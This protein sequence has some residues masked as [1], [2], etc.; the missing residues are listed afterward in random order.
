MKKEWTCFILIFLLCLSLPA[1][2]GK[3][4]PSDRDDSI[5]STESA[6]GY[7]L[8]H[9]KLPGEMVLAVSQYAAGKSI[10]L[11]GMDAS[12]KPLL[13]NY[14]FDNG[15]LLSYPIPSDISYLHA[16]CPSA[17]GVAVLAGDYP[18]FWK[19][20]QKNDVENRQDQYALFLL[21]FDKDGGLETSIPLDLPYSQGAS[22]YSLLYAD[23]CFYLLDASTLYQIS[24]DGVILN[25]RH[26]EG[27]LFISQALSPQGLAV[28]LYSSSLDGGDNAAHV[29]RLVSPEQFTFET[30]YS[31]PDSLLAG[32]GFA[33][34]RMLLRMDGEL[35][36]LSP[37]EGEIQ[38]VFRFRENGISAPY[39]TI[40]QI[41]TVLFLAGRNQSSID[42]LV[43]GE[44]PKTEE[45]L[46][47]V[48]YSAE[49]LPALVAGF[50]RDNSR[51]HIQVE[52]VD[53]NDSTLQAKIVAGEGPDLF[54]TGTGSMF[55]SY[56]NEAVFEDL[57]PYLD[58]STVVN[59]DSLFPSILDAIMLDGKL[60]TFPIDMELYTMVCTRPD[61]VTEKMSFMD[62]MNLPEIESGSM[63]Y[64]TAECSRTVMWQ[65]LSK[66]YQANHIDFKHGTC[67][68]D[69]PEYV[70][71]LKSCMV[72]TPD[73]SG[74]SRDEVPCLFYH[75]SFPGLGR[76]LFWQVQ[77][78][79]D[80][81][82]A[83]GMGVGLTVP[84]A[85][86]I[87]KSSFHKEGAWAFIEYAFT[88]DLPDD[89]RFVLPASKTSLSRLLE[90]GK[91]TGFWYDPKQEYIMLDEYAVRVFNELL[92]RPVALMNQYPELTQIINEEAEKFFAGDC[93][94]EDAAK[95][96]QSRAAIFMA[97]RF[98]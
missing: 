65:W 47:W 54:F 18:V 67:E 72:A 59:R 37:G 60:Y 41:D 29:E 30:L 8:V 44:N 92:S 15:E 34:D 83:P 25:Q 55:T 69:T 27:G 73:E 11:C 62:T 89:P 6:Y 10:Y 12:S 14:N 57:L 93:S 84:D 26:L 23:S 46:L 38:A 74:L 17:D 77:R 5:S 87:A 24:T 81:C 90:S 33:D 52:Y 85:F 63:R 9:E 97:E 96:T 68:F 80:Y 71:L 40:F 49:M 94:A 88:Q 98:G 78:G 3:T 20:A 75:D 66:M 51:Y 79:D 91:T 45:L 28:A 95:A 36:Q 53:S 31:D 43:Y 39:D 1:C 16:C 61:L 32:I 64:I 50:N 86:S 19:N 4:M 48:P 70:D 76:L 22:F 13:Y 42:Y 82:F 58:S 2:G 56:Q 21:L 7:Q 35:S